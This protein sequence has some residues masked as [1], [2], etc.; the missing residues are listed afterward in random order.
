MSAYDDAD[1]ETETP[2]ARRARLRDAARQ[3]R[4]GSVHD[5]FRSKL[6]PN[7]DFYDPA[8]VLAFEAEHPENA[9]RKS[10]LIRHRFHC[11]ETR[12][13]QRLYYLIH[14]DEQTARA[15]DAATVNRLHRLEA[16][17]IAARADRMRGVTEP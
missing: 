5:A 1:P 3:R 9:G 14:E 11:T 15:I 12:Y 4:A 10:E 13:Q 2:D 17:H 8:A 6:R 7:A 16:A